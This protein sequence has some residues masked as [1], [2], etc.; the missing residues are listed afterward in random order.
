MD[1]DTLGYYVRI[2][3]VRRMDGMSNH[4]KAII[5]NKV[6]DIPDQIGGRGHVSQQMKDKLAE[7][8]GLV[9]FWELKES[10]IILELAIWKLNLIGAETDVERRQHLRKECGRYMQVIMS[11]V[12]QFFEY[13]TE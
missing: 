4:H 10:L 3:F 5:V 8:H 11:G 6:N 12:L 9:T 2:D 1:I 13:N 7:I